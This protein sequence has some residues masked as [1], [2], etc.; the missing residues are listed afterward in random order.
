MIRETLYPGPLPTQSWSLP[1][2]EEWLKSHGFPLSMQN[3]PRTFGVT[4]PTFDWQNAPT[5]KDP[6]FFLTLDAWLVCWLQFFPPVALID[7]AIFI[8]WPISASP[9]KLTVTVFT[10]FKKLKLGLG[11]NKT[12]E[13]TVKSK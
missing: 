2:H 7:R 9:I 10:F 5:N 1:L 8:S 13:T 4:S 6:S 11:N 12:R 3:A